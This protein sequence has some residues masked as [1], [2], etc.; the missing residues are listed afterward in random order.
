MLENIRRAEVMTMAANQD[1]RCVVG[2][3]TLPHDSI[4]LIVRVWSEINLP[5][6][7]IEPDQFA[8]SIADV[9][10]TD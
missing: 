4:S 8:D 9:V 1:D 3:V 2:E 5:L 10:P 7:T 6:V